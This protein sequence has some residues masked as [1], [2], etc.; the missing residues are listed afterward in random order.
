MS[1]GVAEYKGTL[2]AVSGTASVALVIHFGMINQV[3]VES[4]TGT[5]TFDVAVSNSSEHELY[6]SNDNT[7]IV[8]EKVDLAIR[9]N[10]LLTIA[11]ASADEELT[12][13]VSV[14]ERY[15]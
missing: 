9:G 4:A 3:I 2:T 1:L 14:V 13:Y 8:S 11:N 6:V 7:G 15:D 5:T 10:G 12:Y